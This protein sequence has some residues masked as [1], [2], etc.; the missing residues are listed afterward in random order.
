MG[1]KS[2]KKQQ[3]KKTTPSSGTPRQVTTFTPASLG[4]GGAKKVSTFKGGAT[5]ILQIPSQYIRQDIIRLFLLLVITILLL[6]VAYIINI[7]TSYIDRA[8]GEITQFLNLG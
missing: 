7:K 3:N 2:R 8:G 1:K 5:N 6:T 4:G